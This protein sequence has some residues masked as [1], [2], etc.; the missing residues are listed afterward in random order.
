MISAQIGGS[1][2]LSDCLNLLEMV[3]LQ[4]IE[5]HSCIYPKS[6]AARTRHAGTKEE[7][8]YSSFI[9]DLWQ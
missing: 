3:P 5:T 8:R 7:R 1:V 4:R 2:G 9:L 6:K